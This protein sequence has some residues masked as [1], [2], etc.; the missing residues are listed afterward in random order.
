MTKNILI[1]LCYADGLHGGVKYTAELGSFFHSIGYTVYCVGVKTNDVTKD[2]FKKYNVTLVNIKDFNFDIHFDLVWAHHFPIFPYLVRHG[3]KY[4]KI[5]NSC[6][7]SILYIE[8]PIF[9]IENIDLILTPTEK[10]KQTF[11]KNYDIPAEKIYVLPNTAPDI[12]F[13]NKKNT[14]K[15]LSKIA[16]VSNHVPEELK[17]AKKL[18]KSKGISVICYGGKNPV[19]ITPQVLSEYDAVISIGKTVQYCLAMEIPVYNYDHFGGSGYITPE[20]L[21]T[22][23]A[24]NFSGRSFF[25]KKSPEQ[26]SEEII[27][28]YDS[29]VSKTNKLT[30]IAEQKFKLSVRI[31]E[32]LSILSKTKKTK[33]LKENNKNRLLFDYCE[34]VI[35]ALAGHKKKKEN[36]FKR[37]LRHLIAMK[38]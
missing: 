3:L 2:F 35:N 16:I 27:Q 20:N 6:I 21:E 28:Q 14:H 9:C 17:K 23:L 11:I 36:T 1:T 4:K 33:K 30:S 32:V 34:F 31:N 13:Q 37:F 29:A 19:D 18:L 10:T 12:F 26:I 38:F 22:E 24:A 15:K 5:I 25:T 7:S 8:K